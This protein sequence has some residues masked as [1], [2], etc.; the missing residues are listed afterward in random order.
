M[1]T[2]LNNSYKDNGNYITKQ[3]IRKM[4][5]VKMKKLGFGNV[6]KKEMLETF[7]E[8]VPYWGKTGNQYNQYQQRHTKYVHLLELYKKVFKY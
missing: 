3:D 5:K 6:T 1:F 2:N 4:S 8:C 7:D